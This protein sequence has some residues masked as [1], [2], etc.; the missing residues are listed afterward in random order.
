VKATTNELLGFEGREEGI[1]AHAVAT[2]R[3]RT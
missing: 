1:A 3:R 2:I